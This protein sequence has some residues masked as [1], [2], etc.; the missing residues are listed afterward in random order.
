MHALFRNFKFVK[1]SIKPPRKRSTEEIAAQAATYRLKKSQ[2][3]EVDNSS[4]R[5]N[6]QRAQI[7]AGLASYSGEWSS[8]QAKHLLRRTLFGARKTEVAQ[9]S[10]MDSSAAVDALLQ[11]EVLP[12]PPV[13]D[14]NEF[15]EE[16]DP[17][18]PYGQPWVESPY[19][20]SHEG[21]K[22]YSLK[23]WVLDQMLNQSPTIHQKLILFW[24]NLLPTQMWGVFH[25]KTSY[26]YWKM[27]HENAF[28]NYKDLIKQLTLDPCMLFYLNGTFNHK[29]A[30]DENYARELQELFCI[31][32]GPNSGYTEADVQAAARILTGWVIIGDS[33]YGEGEPISVFADAVIQDPN[34]YWHDESN[35]QFSEFYNNTVIQ[36]RSGPEGAQEL[37][38]MLDMI[39]SND[40]T[41]LYICRRLYNFFVYHEI[42]EITEQNVIQ[43]LAQIF[44]DNNYEILPVL[45]ALLKSEHFFDEANYGAYIKSPIDHSI[46]LW[47]SLEIPQ[48]GLSEET[49]AQKLLRNVYLNFEM[50]DRGMEV[51]D[52]PS[53]AGWQAYYQE[54]NYDRIWLSADSF[55]SRI[56]SQDNLI[57]NHN[58]AGIDLPGFSL[59]DFAEELENPENPQALVEESSNL[60]LGL[61]LSEENKIGLEGIL[62]PIGNQWVLEWNDYQADPS[63]EMKKT[64]VESRLKAL[65]QAMLQMGEF[66]LM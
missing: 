17:N 7:S 58:S 26:R 1:E 43:P 29:N 61:P 42:D 6:H 65:F 25:A 11:P 4:A 56:R 39:F 33:I 62:D 14:Y 27:L 30:P 32:K 63:N 35:K 5:V 41:A 31:G 57:W 18:V 19:S 66:Q 55:L 10:A 51:G 37:D 48:K 38:D 59:I 46:G 28:G 52:P 12:D 49:P 53:V 16:P 54:P 47:R 22:I 8:A 34:N 3:F 60:L 21:L 13:N 24:H 50:A 2:E 9:F 45:S 64:V 23:S 36:G 40:E 15:A 20:N 44:R